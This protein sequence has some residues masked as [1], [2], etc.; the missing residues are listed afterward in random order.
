MT[1][2][3]AEADQHESNGPRSSTPTGD[4]WPQVAR[5]VVGALAVVAGL[6]LLAVAYHDAETSSSLAHYHLFWAGMLLAL[7]P[8]AVW[9]LRSDTTLS[10]HL[11]L[12]GIGVVTYAPRFLRSPDRPLLYD[13][14][15]HW[16]QTQR[17][18]ETGHLFQS[19]SVVGMAKYY[20]GLHVLTGGVQLLTGLSTYRAGTIIIL[21]L[22]VLTLWGVFELAR[23]SRLG[24]F[25]TATAAALVYALSP[26]FSFFDAQFAYQSMAVPFVIWTLVFVTRFLAAETERQRWAAGV[27][28]VGS[29]AVVAV[30]H[31]LSGLVLTGALVI[32]AVAYVLQ[33]RPQRAR[34]VSVLVAAALLPVL[35]AAAVRAP[36]IDYLRPY[37][38]KG[39]HELAQ[40]VGIEDK[41]VVTNDGRR[42][43]VSGQRQ[44]FGGSDLPA[45]E[46]DAAYAAPV[47][48]FL[49]AALAVL[50]LRR[51]RLGAPDWIIAVLGLGYFLSLPLVYTTTGAQGAHRSWAFSYIGLAVLAGAGIAHLL[52]AAN[53]RRWFGRTLA[54]ACLVALLVGN[55]AAEN[56]DRVRFPGPYT[57][58]ADGRGVT[59]ELRGLADR[60][61]R[62]GGEDERVIT[63]VLTGSVMAAYGR[64]TYLRDYPSW[65]VFYPL[66][67]LGE[68]VHQKLVHD[69][70]QAI[71]VDRR[72]STDVRSRAFYFSDSEPPNRGVLPTP[73][74][75]KFDQTPWLTLRYRTE[76]YRIYEVR[77]PR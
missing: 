37:P 65:E 72:M 63:D 18:V 55:Y 2:T 20:P 59:P 76:N 61:R 77:G 44:L 43:V 12:V 67:P 7:T 30:S 13:E 53:R 51:R 1:V 34:R 9:L 54:V 35:W 40:R 15:G 62:G 32:A 58:I 23:A 10:A 19:N 25:R 17:F 49:L 26:T 22:H 27:L 21:V 36:V 38:Q 69:G 45:Y 47:I 74:I 24:T 6:A 33:G 31:H 11:A 75:R 16:L 41:P 57:F 68:A 29:A 66:R 39:A 48:A 8:P 73:A 70:V 28:A 71:V 50:G 46:R 5:C 64:A 14:L 56:N 4:R 52:G 60:F 42:V 3:A